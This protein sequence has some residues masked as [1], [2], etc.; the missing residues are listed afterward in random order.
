[1]AYHP[2][3]IAQIIQETPDAR[4]FVFDVPADLAERFKYKAGQFLTFRVA[5]LEGEVARCYSLCSSPETDARLKVN[6]KIIAVGNGTAEYVDVVEMKLTKVVDMIRGKSGTR[7]RLKVLTAATNDIKIYELTRRSVEQLFELGCGLVVLACNTA[8]AV[9]LRKL[10]QEW[11]PQAYPQHRV[12]GVLVPMVEALART[13]WYSETPGPD[14]PQAP[15]E[16]IAVFA[17]SATVTAGSYVDEV[18]KRA[19]RV[20]VLQRPCP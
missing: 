15:A 17:T 18:R 2:L 6:D 16:M 1:M 19:P 13:N 20:A 12:L 5:H 3:K 9:A 4:S 10:Q 7:V 14:A 11:L 8:S